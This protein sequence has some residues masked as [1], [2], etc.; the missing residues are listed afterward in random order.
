M[1][2]TCSG[3]FV[4]ILCTEVTMIVIQI[5]ILLRLFMETENIAG[6]N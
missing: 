2:K 6:A 4:W 5:L 3:Y 1:E